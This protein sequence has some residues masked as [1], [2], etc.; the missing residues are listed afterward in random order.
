MS[1]TYGPFATSNLHRPKPVAEITICGAIH[2]YI[3]DTMDFIKPTPE[4]I[5]NLHDLF[6]ID[7]MLMEEE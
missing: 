1:S 5:K 6:C 7:V 3:D 2:I 4:Q